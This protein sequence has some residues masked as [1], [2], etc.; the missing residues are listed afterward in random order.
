MT[1]KLN[2]NLGAQ[3]HL[4]LSNLPSS[5]S[6]PSSSHSFGK[7][8][9]SC[10]SPSSLKNCIEQEN[11]ISICDSPLKKVPF[12]DPPP[13]SP[14][15]SPP[16]HKRFC[17]SP[18][19][20][21]VGLSSNASPPARSLS[22]NDTSTIA[23][24]VAKAL[25]INRPRPEFSSLS[26]NINRPC[27]DFSC[28]SQ[29]TNSRPAPP[30]APRKSSSRSRIAREIDFTPPPP[31]NQPIVEVC[32]Q[33]ANNIH[34]QF[35]VK[36]VEGA[37]GDFVQ[38]YSIIG[39]LYSVKTRTE[40]V[41]KAFHDTRIEESRPMLNKYIG[42][43]LKQYQDLIK[44]NVRIAEIFNQPAKDGYYLMEYVPH[45]F[46]LKLK[47]PSENLELDLNYWR[48]NGKLS[49]LDPLSLQQLEQVRQTMNIAVQNNIPMD[50]KPDN[51][52]VRENG[53][54]CLVDLMEE[55]DAVL[56]PCLNQALRRWCNGNIDLFYFFIKD[57]PPQF[58]ENVISNF[59]RPSK[60][61]PEGWVLSI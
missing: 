46:V 6:S 61:A 2:T 5:P 37:K 18:P 25:F 44:L 48:K 39:Q 28:L 13:A 3:S 38:L 20:Q 27:P 4:D 26:H 29:S 16:N 30:L 49:D 7:R 8:K 32:Q 15:S 47:C 1:I 35:K 53:D 12:P 10:S 51:W 33:F 34:P 42:T 9:V 19:S 24:G 17:A 59:R 57:F 58:K 54:A 21:N 56:L 23:S 11:N 40:L 52:R 22:A 43:A 31:P 50:L 41:I 60:E 14:P 36:A 45:P 55:D